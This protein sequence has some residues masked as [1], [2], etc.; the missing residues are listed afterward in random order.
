MQESILDGCFERSMITIMKKEIEKLIADW[1]TLKLVEKVSSAG[2]QIR[3]DGLEELEKAL[4]N[5]GLTKDQ[6]NALKGF[7]LPKQLPVSAPGNQ[8]L[9]AKIIAAVEKAE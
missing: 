3:L 7:D 2:K 8:K 4:I 5:N 9:F 1:V 6:V